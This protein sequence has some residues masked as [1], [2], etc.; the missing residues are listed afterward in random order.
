MLTQGSWLAVHAKADQTSPVLRGKFV[1][2]QLFCKPPP[3]PPPI[4]RRR[5][6]GRRSAAARRASGSRS[7]PPTPFCA[8]CHTLMD[9]I[10][11]A[12]ENYDADGRLARHRRRPAG[13]RD[14]VAD[15][16]RRRRRPRRR[17]QPGD[18]AGRQRRGGELRG[19]AVVPLRLRPQRADQRRSLRHLGAGGHADRRPGRRLQEDGARR[20]SGWPSS[21]TSRRRAHAMKPL[22]QTDD[23]ARRRRRGHRAPLPRGDARRDEGARRDGAQALRRDVLGERDAPD[24]W[25]PTGSETELHAVADPVAAGRRHQSDLVIVEGLLQ[26][27]GGGDGHQNGIGGM[28]TGSPLNPGPFAGVGAPPAGWPTGPSVDQRIA[29][30]L[31]GP[32]AATARSSSA[33]RWG[34]PTTGDG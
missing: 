20:P 27:G 1:R 9:P 6:A 7:T 17:P 4:D 2:A 26:E 31:G 14:R 23:P 16:H 10:G 24:G 11:F 29:E 8:M 3:P 12:F 28:L 25:T 34:P 19:H 21:A 30:A 13:R 5:A 22:S 32:D 15:R 33:S 18:A